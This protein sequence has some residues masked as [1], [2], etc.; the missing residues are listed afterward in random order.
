MAN[1]LFPLM[2]YKFCRGVYTE[3]CKVDL[4]PNFA[5]QFLTFTE[6]IR[7]LFIRLVASLF[8]R[9]YTLRGRRAVYL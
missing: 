1:L 7:L 9:I 8:L 3:Q 2:F 5:K 6:K 4:L